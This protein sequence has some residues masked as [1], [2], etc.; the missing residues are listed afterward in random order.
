M[1]GHEINFTAKPFLVKEDV[2][3]LGKDQTCRIS[4]TMVR[5][6]RHRMRFYSG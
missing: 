5:M 2:K 3:A 6:G 1:K 4:Q